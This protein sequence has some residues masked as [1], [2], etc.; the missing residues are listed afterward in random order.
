[1]VL[2]RSVLRLRTSENWE[3]TSRGATALLSSFSH[4]NKCMLAALLLVCTPVGAL[5]DIASDEDE[6][7]HEFVFPREFRRFHG[8][9]GRYPKT[10]I[11]LGIRMGCTGYDIRDSRYL[12]KPS[13]AI[14]W[15]PDNCQLA[16][17]IQFADKRSFRVVALAKGHVVSINDTFRV[18]YLKTPYHSHEPPQCPPQSAC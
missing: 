6:L 10:W 8:K 18:T 13:E 4:V 17:K 15:K 9:Y 2:L 16:Y 12:P 5:A 3:V 11:E 7:M 1:M 14:V